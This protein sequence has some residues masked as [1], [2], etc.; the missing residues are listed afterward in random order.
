[1]DQFPDRKTYFNWTNVEQFLLVK[2]RS[3]CVDAYALNVVWNELKYKAKVHK[4]YG[5]L[6]LVRCVPAQINQVFMNI[7]INAAHAIE[8][9]G[10]ITLKTGIAGDEVW[11]S[12]TDTGKGMP[13]SVRNRIFEPFFTTKP[14]GQGTGLG[15]SLAYSII[16][17][18]KGH[19][20]VESTEG[21]GTTFKIYLPIAGKGEQLPDRE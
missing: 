13:E 10:E 3:R 5:V 6:P 19:I 14:V 21:V 20:E 4:E 9:M 8:G 18:H 15:L 12:V 2:Y 1:M 17:K 16:Q 11:I 7:M